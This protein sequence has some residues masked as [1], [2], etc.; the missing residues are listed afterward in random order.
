MSFTVFIG[1]MILGFFSGFMT[2]AL[3][4]AR[5]RR[6]QREETDAMDDF[7]ACACPPIHKSIP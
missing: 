3:L 7:D 1:G 6:F 2:M 5:G 4:A